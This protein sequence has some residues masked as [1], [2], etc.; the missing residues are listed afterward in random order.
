M[1]YLQFNESFWDAVHAPRI[2]HQ[3]YPMEISFDD[4]LPEEIV[5]GLK[6][7]GHVMVK[8]P[9][10]GFASVTAIGRDGDKLVPVYHPIRGGSSSV[11]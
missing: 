3:L 8:A 4:E 7:L 2:H 5:T 6:R 9:N 10:I 1:R 11:F